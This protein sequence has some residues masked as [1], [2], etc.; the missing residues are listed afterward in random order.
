MD[1]NFNKI[2][3]VMY[4]VL[5]PLIM[6]F[7]TAVA[8]DGIS[9]PST[10]QVVLGFMTLGINGYTLYSYIRQLTE[11]LSNRFSKDNTNA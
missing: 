4:W 7:T 10:F 9:S 3:N 8:F 11:K 2:L 5:I 6:M 1:A